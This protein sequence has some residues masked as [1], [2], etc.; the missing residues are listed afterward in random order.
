MNSPIVW[1]VWHLIVRVRS[2]TLSWVSWPIGEPSIRSILCI[3]PVSRS[4][5]VPLH[6][7]HRSSGSRLEVVVLCGLREGIG[8]G[9]GE[10]SVG[11]GDELSDVLARGLTRGWTGKKRLG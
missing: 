4:K 11:L 6:R 3:G 10:G 8:L 5:S 9:V 7:D 1:D 2:R